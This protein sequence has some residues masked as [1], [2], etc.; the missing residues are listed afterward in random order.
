MKS[1]NK[2]TNSPEFQAAVSEM[3]RF[4]KENE[5]PNVLEFS[6]NWRWNGFFSV[7]F[8]VKYYENSDGYK[9]KVL[10][11]FYSL[12]DAQSIMQQFDDKVVLQV[13][14]IVIKIKQQQAITR[15]Q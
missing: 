2:F 3:E 5:I 1:Y 8:E 6:I 14:E 7:Y 9:G 12:F 4:L 15:K 10:S 11:I 13:N